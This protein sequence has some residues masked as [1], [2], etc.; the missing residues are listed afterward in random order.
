MAEAEDPYKHQDLIDITKQGGDCVT[1]TGVLPG[2]YNGD[3][4]MDVLITCQSKDQ[5]DISISV[6][7]YWGSQRFIN[8]GKFL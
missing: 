2:D 3:N 8:V 4:Q 7:I 1:I 6:Y 5:T